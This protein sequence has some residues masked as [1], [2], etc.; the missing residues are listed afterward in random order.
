MRY[1][2]SKKSN[3]NSYLMLKNT[4]HKFFSYLGNN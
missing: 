3:L 2:N 4:M 1:I